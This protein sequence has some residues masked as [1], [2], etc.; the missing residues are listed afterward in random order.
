MTTIIEPNNGGPCIQRT[1][2]RGATTFELREWP[3][4]VARARSVRENRVPVRSQGRDVA[5]RFGKA[6][7]A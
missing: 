4:H 5:G 2:T 7:L 3:L 1:I 6:V